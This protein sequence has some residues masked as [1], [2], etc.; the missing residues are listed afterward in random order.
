[1]LAKHETTIKYEF[2]I[3]SYLFIHLQKNFLNYYILKK[4]FSN[5]QVYYLNL[6]IYSF[7]LF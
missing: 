4:F 5:E 3:A 2:L 7:L 1:M 6:T